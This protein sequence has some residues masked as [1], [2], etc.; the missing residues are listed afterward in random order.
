MHAA[1]RSVSMVSMLARSQL[2]GLFTLASS[3]NS[4]SILLARASSHPNAKTFW[5][6][7][8]PHPQL[9]PM[10]LIFCPARLPP[11]SS[12]MICLLADTPAAQ[13]L[14]SIANMASTVNMLDKSQ[15][16][17]M[18]TLANNSSSTILLARANSRPSVKT[19]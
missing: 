12:A 16:L 14:V 17:V 8:L 4:S 15:L 9:V 10:A 18:F 1:Q 7:Q 11:R 19:F 13:R 6:S 3:S 5:H 2:P